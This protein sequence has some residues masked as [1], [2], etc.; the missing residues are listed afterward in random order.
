MKMMLGHLTEHPNLKIIVFDEDTIL[1][2]PIEAW[3]I[4]HCFLSF[5]SLGFPLN[6]A[7]AYWHLR[8]PVL[9]NDLEAQHDLQDRLVLLL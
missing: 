1:N 9:I 4:C 8:K 7:I 3:P 6:K 2:K 5:F